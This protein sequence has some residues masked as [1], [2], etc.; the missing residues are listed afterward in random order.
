[1]E[2]DKP[3]SR[4]RRFADRL[5]VEKEPGLNTSQLMLTNYDLKPVE[6]SHSPSMWP[7]AIANLH[8]LLGK[9]IYITFCA[10]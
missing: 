3:R 4:F 7:I 5:A 2:E 10:Y 1:M 6:V 9:H 8:C